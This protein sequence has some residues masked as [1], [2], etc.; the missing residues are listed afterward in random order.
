MTNFNLFSGIVIISGCLLG[1][2]LVS[3]LIPVV[4]W[5]MVSAGLGLAIVNAWAARGA[6]HRAVGAS[7]RNFIGWGMIAHACRML[8]VAG[9]F[10]FIK[11]SWSEE[12]CSFFIPFFS[13]MFWFMVLEVAWLL[14]EQNDRGSSIERVESN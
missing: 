4:S 7:R 8:T 12:A 9:I 11:I 1:V 6:N 13:V 2:G 10:A 3:W 14:K 5:G